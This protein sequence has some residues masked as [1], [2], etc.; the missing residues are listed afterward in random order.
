MIEIIFNVRLQL[1]IT[2]KRIVKQIGYNKE[3]TG[4]KTN[5]Y[6]GV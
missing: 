5:K 6:N 1:R 3:A 4:K 2:T